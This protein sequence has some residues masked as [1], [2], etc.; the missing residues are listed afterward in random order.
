LAQ[1]LNLVLSDDEHRESVRLDARAVRDAWSNGAEQAAGLI[2]SAHRART[3]DTALDR[4][5][6]ALRV[7]VELLVG[8]LLRRTHRKAHREYVLTRELTPALMGAETPLEHMLPTSSEEYSG[9]RSRLA[10]EWLLS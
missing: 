7:E 5:K 6:I 4:L 8:N 2:V 1:V 9:H 10:K 3:R